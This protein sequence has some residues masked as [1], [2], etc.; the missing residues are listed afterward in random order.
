MQLLI[1]VAHGATSS[2]SDLL[3][4][5]QQAAKGAKPKKGRENDPSARQEAVVELLQASALYL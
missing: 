5:A 1:F 3:R 4:L 2:S